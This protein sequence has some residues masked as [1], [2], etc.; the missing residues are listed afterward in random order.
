MVNNHGLQSKWWEG[1]DFLKAKNLG[2]LGTKAWR[3]HIDVNAHWRK[4]I[5]GIYGLDGGLSSTGSGNNK[6]SVWTDIV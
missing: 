6:V 5:Q 4:V 3:Y 1:I 2:L